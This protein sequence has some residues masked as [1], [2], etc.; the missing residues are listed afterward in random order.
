MDTRTADDELCRRIA[1][2]YKQALAGR[3]PDAFD[4]LD[5]APAICRTVP[6][7]EEADLFCAMKCRAVREWRRR[8]ALRFS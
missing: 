3:D 1:R 7:A 8:Q 6:D 2:A 4:V 5:L